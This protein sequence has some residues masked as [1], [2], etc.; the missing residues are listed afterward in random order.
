MNG[1]GSEFEGVG[2]N[3]AKGGSS[4]DMLD[5]QDVGS[6]DRKYRVDRVVMTLLGSHIQT[7]KI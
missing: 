2:S 5:R 7:E 3:K 4:D 1:T 6:S